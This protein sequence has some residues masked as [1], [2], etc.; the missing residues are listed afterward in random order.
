[1][2][3]LRA[4]VGSAG[5]RLRRAEDVTKD[6]VREVHGKE[7]GEWR[8]KRRPACIQHRTHSS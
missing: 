1:M 8:M 4:S 3:A 6:G 2:N 5:E 7:E